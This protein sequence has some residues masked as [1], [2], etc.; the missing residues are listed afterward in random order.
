MKGLVKG[1]LT[2][3]GKGSAGGKVGGPPDFSV[4]LTSGSLSSLHSFIG[5]SAFGGLDVSVQA[6]LHACAAGGV[7]GSL[8]LSIHASLSSWISSLHCP[9]DAGLKAA[10]GLWLQGSVG[11]GVQAAG[12]ATFPYVTVGSHITG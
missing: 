11:T 2:A 1:W 8:D 3:G 4:V 6:G 10:I 7:A 9:L 5:G 12:T